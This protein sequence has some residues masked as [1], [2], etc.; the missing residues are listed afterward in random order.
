[1]P[2]PR[3][4]CTTPPDVM[5]RTT[6]PSMS[7]TS[8]LPSPGATATLMGL[9]NCAALMSPPLPVDAAV[10]SPPH[11]VM[12]RVVSDTRRRRW[13]KRS[14]ISSQS[15]CRAMP[16][17]LSSCAS[18]AAPPS[19]LKPRVP[20]SFTHMSVTP[21]V[22]LTRRT[23]LSS[24]LDTNTASRHAANA[25]TGPK[26]VPLAS[27]PDVAASPLYRHA[28]LPATRYVSPLVD[29]T[30]SARHLSG[31]PTTR[32]PLGMKPACDTLP[33]AAEVGMT[34]ISD[35]V[36]AP[37]PSTVSMMPVASVTRRTRLLPQS[38]IQRK[39]LVAAT[40]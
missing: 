33:T 9:L 19:P 23:R 5:R 34:P 29:D 32:S 38:V 6:Q 37:L 1:V 2:S 11:V 27:T 40:P 8:T 3:N 24:R 36:S 21:V 39:A 20:A 15:P 26:A 16:S 10:P 28:P 30:A 13:L 17:G 4:A 14:Q 22:T 12:M 25:C 18:T 31:S 35:P 7:T